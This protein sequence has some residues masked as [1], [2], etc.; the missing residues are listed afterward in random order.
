MIVTKR[1]GR[2]IQPN[3]GTENNQAETSDYLSA[4]DL[5][6]PE[7]GYTA[8]NDL[9]QNDYER[10]QY[11]Q[12]EQDREQ[13][14]GVT[15][16]NEFQQDEETNYYLTPLTVPSH[17][18]SNSDYEFRDYEVSP[19]EVGLVPN[20]KKTYSPDDFRDYEVSPF[21]FRHVQRNP[22][23]NNISIDNE[24]LNIE[25]SQSNGHDASDD[26]TDY[27]V[28]SIEIRPVEE[29]VSPEFIREVE[30]TQD[31]GDHEPL[32][33]LIS[34][35]IYEEFEMRTLMPSSAIQRRPTE[36]SR[37]LLSSLTKTNLTLGT[38]V[39]VL[40]V[41]LLAVLFV[42]V[43]KGKSYLNSFHYLKNF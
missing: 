22:L 38:I 27:E 21:E 35:P 30:D 16:L 14:S 6:H 10:P 24:I 17:R 23:T 9:P 29:N 20:S 4:E 43:T 36:P 3:L 41:S 42:F 13:G 18:S 31:S 5:G 7:A 28:A 8:L 19:S 25:Y 32:Y 1:E 15:S 12:T 2:E 34:E 39:V 26:S 33:E 40:L 11:A 37:G